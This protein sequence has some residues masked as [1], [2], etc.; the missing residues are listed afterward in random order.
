MGEHLRAQHLVE[1]GGE[2]GRT[3]QKETWEAQPSC[4]KAPSRPCRS[5]GARTVLQSRLALREEGQA[6][7]APTLLAG[8]GPLGHQPGPQGERSPLPVMTPGGNWA[9]HHQPQRQKVA[10]HP[11]S[12]TQA[13]LPAQGCCSSDPWALCPQAGDGARNARV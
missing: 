5:P 12:R 13:S 10:V 3:E 7:V 9:E 1:G 8:C 11:A 2:E 6:F 4:S